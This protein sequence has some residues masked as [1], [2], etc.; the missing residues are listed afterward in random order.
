MQLKVSKDKIK[1]IKTFQGI[2]IK[3]N[4]E[5]K[6]LVAV[7]PLDTEYKEYD[8]FIIFEVPDELFKNKRLFRFDINFIENYKL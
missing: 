6:Y 1:L 7:L 4:K 2:Y 3:T 8:N 5:Y